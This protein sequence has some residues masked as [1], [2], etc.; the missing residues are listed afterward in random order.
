M[1][2]AADCDLQPGGGQ[3]AGAPA[4]PHRHHA[5]GGR[6]AHLRGPGCGGHGGLALPVVALQSGYTSFALHRQVVGDVL[7]RTVNLELVLLQD[8]AAGMLKEA[9]QTT[10]DLRSQVR[11]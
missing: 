4:G 11:R 5:V 10:E 2:A 9:E 3:P 7:Q 6:A 8:D 1:L